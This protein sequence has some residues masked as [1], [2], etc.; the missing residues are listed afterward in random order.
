MSWQ[1]GQPGLSRNPT[2][3]LHVDLFLSSTLNILI[4]WTNLTGYSFL[5]FRKSTNHFCLLFNS[6]DRF[7]KFLNLQTTGLFSNKDKCTKIDAKEKQQELLLRVGR[8]K[9][10]NIRAKHEM[11]LE[12]RKLKQVSTDHTAPRKHDQD[13]HSQ[14]L[15]KISI[16]GWKRKLR[17]PIVSLSNDKVDH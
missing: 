14:D 7:Q 3:H 2:S 15:Y 13:M 9:F 8:F 4:T 10:W 16:K 1:Y 11:S 5:P 12:N 17:Y 6:P